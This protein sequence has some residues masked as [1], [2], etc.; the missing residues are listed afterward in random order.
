MQT[1]YLTNEEVVQKL[2]EI[3]DAEFLD[4]V[5]KTGENCVYSS[6]IKNIDGKGSNV[7]KESGEAEEESAAD[8]I[9]KTVS[10]QNIEPGNIERNENYRKHVN[11]MVDDA[12][13][14]GKTVSEMAQKVLKAY[15]NI[16]IN[17]KNKFKQLKGIEPE[18]KMYQTTVE[19]EKT[20]ESL[21]YQMNSG[22]LK[23]LFE[24]GN[25]SPYNKMTDEERIDNINKTLIGGV[26][27]ISQWTQEDEQKKDN[28]EK[29]EVDESGSSRK[30]KGQNNPPSKSD[31]DRNT[32]DRGTFSKMGS[33]RHITPYCIISE[34]ENVIEYMQ[35]HNIGSEDV[36]SKMRGVLSEAKMKHNEKNDDNKNKYCAIVIKKLPLVKDGKVIV[37]GGNGHESINDSSCQKM[38]DDVM[39]IHN[40]ESERID[41]IHCTDQNKST[42]KAKKG[43][44][45]EQNLAFYNKKGDGLVPELDVWVRPFNFKEETKGEEPKQPTP[46]TGDTNLWMD[47]IQ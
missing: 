28:G 18:F 24:D 45:L 32:P 7:I 17:T 1:E 29:S 14:V 41:M 2:E 44:L 11:Q 33:R 39:K 5:K 6:I 23:L 46:P 16:F 34:T 10:A 31:E 8:V 35:H 22:I 38:L 12:E 36:Y 4:N 47:I 26:L 20:D 21:D 15:K 25:D 30:S 19:M 43:E 13:I 27:N 3:N 42:M 40:C 9:K 37:N